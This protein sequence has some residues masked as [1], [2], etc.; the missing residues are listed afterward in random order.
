[1]TTMDR[2]LA[3]LAAGYFAYRL[4]SGWG[5]GVIYGDGD[6]DVHAD[7]HPTAFVLTA[8]SVVFVIAILTFIA[9]GSDMTKLV[10]VTKWLWQT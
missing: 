7:K 8:L 9:I 4:W 6:E 1:M 10:A 3:G 2:V 5:D